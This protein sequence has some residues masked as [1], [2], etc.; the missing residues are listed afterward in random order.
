MAFAWSKISPKQLDVIDG[1]TGF[2]NILSGTVRSGKTI[3]SIIAWMNFVKES[4]HSVFLMSG[5]SI[6]SLY[7]NVISI[8]E[9]ILGSKYAEYKSQGKGG[10]VLYLKFKQG[11]KTITKTCICV[12]AGKADSEK[13]IR[14]IT[15]GGHYGDEIT[16]HHH[17]FVKQAI[18]RM[19]LYGAKAI[20][21]T[22]PD[23]PFNHIKLEYIDMITEKNYK[24]WHFDLDDNLSLSEEYKENIKK[25]YTGLFYKRFILGLWCLAEGAIYGN[26][27]SKKHIINHSALPDKF[28]KM[29]ITSDYGITNAQ[30]FLLC[31]IKYVDKK[32]HV[33][34]I[35]EYYNKEGGRNDLSIMNDYKKF[36]GET[37]IETLIID[38]SAASLINLFKANKI[39][40]KSADN[41][42]LNG[43]NNVSIFIDESR[44]YIV[45]A[46]KNLIKEF[47]SYV[48]DA[49]AQ[50]IGL[51][52]PMKVEDHA[53][54]S[55]RYL[56]QTLF[57]VKDNNIKA[58]H[59]I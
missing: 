2:I 41:S 42:V 12:G 53:L 56:I 55:L 21:T 28:D 11:K 48:W 37:K 3:A 38:P 19:S 26:L 34:I 16:L 5:Y 31:G 7:K 43:I 59:A 6:D 13:R 25:A 20:W 4:P 40:V 54:D 24:H 22:N 14:G 9:D 29:Y 57:P 17:T 32:P 45:D 39:P 52:K 18:N 44:L 33:Y 36:L 46:C 10:A 49:A 50:K 30:V 51:D 1:C 58:V 23:S 8:M 27:D 35:K 15:C 47:E